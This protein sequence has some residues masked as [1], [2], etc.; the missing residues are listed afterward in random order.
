MQS[1]AATNNAS[2][3]Q[4]GWSKAYYFLYYGAASALIPYLVIYYQMNGLSGRQIGFLTGLSP[5]ITLVSAPLWGGF[6]DRTGRHRSLLNL[7]LIGAGAAAI[8]LSLTQSFLFLI[9]VVIAY[10]FFMSPVMPLVDNSVMDML[11]SARKRYGRLRLWGAVGWGVTAPVIGFLIER[12][13][14]RWSF[15]GYL[16]GLVLGLLVVNQLPIKSAGLGNG[17]RRGLKTL[18]TNRRWLAF[19]GLVFVGGISLS[20]VSSF[21]FIRMGDLGAAKTTMG[22][23]LTAATVSEL[24]VLFYGEYFLERWGAS[25][26]LKTAIFFI[27]LRVLAYSFTEVPENFLWIQ[28]LHGVT[29]SAIWMAGVSYAA[30]IAPAGLGATA[31]GLFSGTMLGLSS[32]VGSMLAG[33]LYQGI[34]AVAMFRWLGLLPL[35]GL[36]LYFGFERYWTFSRRT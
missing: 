18:S 26:V 34:G 33:V 4:V 28:L 2:N 12:S 32:A 1:E 31:Q 24:P 17:F 36:L 14:I 30:E 8:M 23:A 9:P 13:G 7:A 27:G 16:V 25:G 22:L 29:F 20:G 5:L 15:I 10:A 21:L 35:A 3:H 11:G 6:A 19:L